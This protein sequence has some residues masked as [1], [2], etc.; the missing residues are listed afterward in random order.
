[1]KK[2][3]LYAIAAIIVGLTLVLVP[4]VALAE[5]RKQDNLG[6]IQTIPKTFIQVEGGNSDIP[7]V[8]QADV[9]TLGACF[10]I[11][12]IGYFFFRKSSHRERVF[13]GA[14]LY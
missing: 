13:P 11:A 5:I 4:L 10:A 6:L 3:P 1:M 7:S 9:E 8:S 14:L 12:L 2:T